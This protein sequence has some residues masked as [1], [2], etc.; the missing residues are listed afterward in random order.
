MSDLTAG[1][2]FAS[3]GT[4]TPTK[5]ND[6]IGNAVIAA[7][8]L[9][10]DSTGLAKMA[11]GYL[12]ADAAGR[13]KMASGF[14]TGAMLPEGSIVQV[15]SEEYTTFSNTSAV[16]PVDNTVPVSTEGEAL[17]SKAITPAS[18]S[19]KVLVRFSGC[20]TAGTATTTMTFALFR[21]TTCIAAKVVTNAGVGA[22]DVTFD[23]LD[24]PAS[25]SAV[26]YYVRYGAQ[27]GYSTIIN[28]A[29]S[30]IFGGIQK[31]V[32]TLMEVKA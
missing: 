10:A 21:G 6:A 26:T 20:A 32:L 14:L 1:Y 8:A 11:D 30:R 31:Q 17:M 12:S 2:T 19:N 3:G 25:A 7:G 15:V 22:A 9:S 28:G 29:G 24:S 27:S 4:V 5:L 13:A 16:I 18:A 23:V